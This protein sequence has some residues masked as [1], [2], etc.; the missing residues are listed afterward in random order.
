MSI[1]KPLSSNK[2]SEWT[3]AEEKARQAAIDVGQM[4]THAATAVGSMAGQAASDVG[5]KADD[6]TASAGVGIQ[7]LG[8]RIS[9]NG[10]QGGMLGTATQAVAKSVVD[11]GA[12]LEDA[13][14]SGF[15]EDMTQL[16]RRNPIPAVMI[17]I[18]LGWIIASR[19]RS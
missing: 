14:L 9:K 2:S 11:G 1:T 17:A 16:I 4:A 15:A 7:G 5:K 6:L 12:Y 13:K 19:M 18:G 3:Q 8:D 10:P